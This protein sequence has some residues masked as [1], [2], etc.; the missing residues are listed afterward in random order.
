MGLCVRFLFIRI[1]ILL[2]LFFPSLA[3]ALTTQTITFGTLPTQALGAAP[4]TV[5]ATA[6][7]GLAVSFSSQTTSVCTVSGSIVTLVATGACFIAADQA[8]NGAYSAASEVIQGFAVAGPMVSEVAFTIVTFQWDTDEPSDAYVECAPLSTPTALTRV[9][10]PVQR[11]RHQITVTNLVMS[12]SP[13]FHGRSA[14]LQGR[15]TTW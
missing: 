7:S 15:A 3:S 14:D 13:Q 9:S 11:T 1:L 5:S 10:D 8:G 4:F 2:G 12:S 6:S